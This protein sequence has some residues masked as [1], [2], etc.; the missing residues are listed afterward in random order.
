ML[1]LDLVVEEKL[2]WD[3]GQNHVSLVVVAP[4]SNCSQRL[5]GDAKTRLALGKVVL[6]ARYFQVYVFGLLLKRHPTSQTI[7]QTSKTSDRLLEPGKSKHRASRVQ[8][9]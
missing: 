6:V 5:L 7:G 4:S 1:L 2:L 3:F 8:P 9:I